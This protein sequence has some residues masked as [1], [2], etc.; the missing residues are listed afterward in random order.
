MNWKIE[1]IKNIKPNPNNPRIIGK[2]KFEKLVESI[3]TFPRMMEIRP[4]VV[5]ADGV[6]LGGNMRLKACQEIGLSEIPVICA[7]DL[8]PEQQQQFIIK[9]NVGFGQWNFDMLANHWDE[10]DLID[11]ALDLPVW[12][13]DDDDHD[14]PK[15]N[16]T[17]TLV[18]PD[19]ETKQQAE[20][21]IQEIIDRKF[22]N[23]YIK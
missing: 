6:V 16:I 21:D 12:D 9:D 18:F 23:T 14:E 10:S 2:D 13:G 20:I 22:K 4:I 11:W 19:E 8:T 7:D 1:Q 17:M 3:K 5:D 15:Q